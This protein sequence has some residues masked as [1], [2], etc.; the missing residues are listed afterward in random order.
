[1]VVKQKSSSGCFIDNTIP[2]PRLTIDVKPAQ[3]ANNFNLHSLIKFSKECGRE[4]KRFSIFA[5]KL[6][7]SSW[8]DA[9]T[10]CL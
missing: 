4:P 9:P 10:Q 7:N 5:T 8:L 6:F 2:H 1:M 3:D